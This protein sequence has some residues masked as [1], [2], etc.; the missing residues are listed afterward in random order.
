MTLPLNHPLPPDAALSSATAPGSPPRPARLD[1]LRAPVA[2]F[3]GFLAFAVFLPYPA[4]PV[5]NTSALQLGNALVLLLAIPA[6]LVSWKR[7]PF[8]VF[9]V[10]LAPMCLST[11]KA[12]VV[13]ADPLDVCLKA[14]IVWGVSMMTILAAQLCAPRHALPM[15]L[16]VAAASLLHAALGLF[17]LYRFRQ[18]GDF[19]LPQLYVNPSFLSVQDNATIIARYVQ[20]PFGLFPE[21][22]AMAASLAPWVLI[23]LALAFGLLRLRGTSPATIHRLLF[24]AAG[25]AGLGLIIVSRSGH[26]APTCLAVVALVIAWFARARATAGTFLAVVVVFGIFLPVVVALAAVSVGDRLGGKTAFGNSSWGERADSL[27]AGFDLIARSDLTSNLL[28]MG[29]GQMSPRLKESTGLDAVFSVVLTYVFETGVVGALAAAAVAYLLLRCWIATR[30]NLTF[31]LVFGVW[32]VGVT[33]I[34]SYEPLLPIWFTLGWMTVWPEVFA[35]RRDEGG[36]ETRMED[37]GSRMARTRLR[38]PPSSILHPRLS[39]PPS[40]APEGRKTLA[41][42]VS[43]GTSG[44]A[45]MF[46]LSQPRRGVRMVRRALLPVAHGA[47]TILSPLRGWGIKTT[48]QGAPASHGSRRGLW[49]VAPPGLGWSADLTCRNG[50]GI[51]DAICAAAP[52]TPGQRATPP[53]PRTSAVASRFRKRSA[54]LLAPRSRQGRDGR[55]THSAL[56]DTGL[57][58]VRAIWRAVASLVSFTPRGALA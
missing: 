10:L 22:S 13:G 46:V 19:P 54:L 37:R 50:N 44:A 24:G 38:P 4:L 28:G 47:I 12:A 21:P 23:L 51:G 7:R 35:S 56:C 1:A 16:G 41:H 34:T 14:T 15:L 30:Y 11:M 32:L 48:E 8:W 5:G 53:S 25:L 49:S 55:A 20:R 31:A 36:D 40:P 6:L 27:A 9:P 33:V 2:A 39:P 57:P 58:P 43:R 18:G 29:I 3:C 45:T 52:G 26:A 42:G 17:Q